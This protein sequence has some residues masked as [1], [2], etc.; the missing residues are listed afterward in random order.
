[1]PAGRTSSP[2]RIQ[3]AAQWRDHPKIQELDRA[4]HYICILGDGCPDATDV[5]LILHPAAHGWNDLMWEYL[6]AAVKAARDR[7]RRAKV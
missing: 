3:V 5:D 1:M 7:K 2:L 6:P 4:G